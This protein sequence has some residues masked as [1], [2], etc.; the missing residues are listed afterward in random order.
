MTELTLYNPGAEDYEEARKLLAG[1]F[2]YRERERQEAKS[3][4]M[5]DDVALGVYIDSIDHEIYHKGLESI[6]EAVRQLNP[7]DETVMP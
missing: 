7:A 5:T 6:E 2:E 4:L 3:V 1:E